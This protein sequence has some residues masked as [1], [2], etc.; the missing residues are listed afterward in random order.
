M[1]RFL[2]FLLVSTWLLLL[3]GVISVGAGLYG[4]YHFGKDLPEH[5]S[6]VDY[7]PPIVSRVYASNGRLLAEFATENRVFVPVEAMPRRI[8]NAFIAAEDKNYYSH[9]KKSNK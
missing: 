5:G 4:F 1:K 7:E 8:I 3:V 6:L 2:K 9:N